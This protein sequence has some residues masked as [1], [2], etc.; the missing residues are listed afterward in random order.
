VEYNAFNAIL[1]LWGLILF[2][3]AII[4]MVQLRGIFF[5]FSLGAIG[6]I[7]CYVLG[8]DFPI[9]VAVFAVV[10]A[11]SFLLLRPLFLKF[12]AKNATVHEEGLELLVGLEGKVISKIDVS[13]GTG[14]IDINGRPV[15]AIPVDP[16]QKYNVGDL[17]EVTALEGD[18]LVVRKA[19]KH[20]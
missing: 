3:F 2:G 9:Q 6:A 7:I 14:R 13:A 11:L 12:S 15:K 20:K 1:G 5:N 19:R 4:E 16:Q 8:I 17:V 18:Q 10:T